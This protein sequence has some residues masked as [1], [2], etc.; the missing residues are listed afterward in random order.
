MMTETKAVD[1]AV[2]GVVDIVDVAA[3]HYCYGALALYCKTSAVVAAA[4]YLIPRHQQ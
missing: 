4:E 2:D 1:S 3:F